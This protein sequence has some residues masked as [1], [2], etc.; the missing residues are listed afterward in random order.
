[1]E[2]GRNSW[3]VEGGIVSATS[4]LM[5]APSGATAALGLAATRY[6]VKSAR[7]LGRVARGLFGEKSVMN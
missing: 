5:A 4:A 3:R 6:I 1:L 2:A 7:A